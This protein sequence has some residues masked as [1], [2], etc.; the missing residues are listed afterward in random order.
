MVW[1]RPGLY[2]YTQPINKEDIMKHVMLKKVATLLI[3]LALAVTT[4]ACSGGSGLPES[5]ASE[6]SGIDT[7]IPGEEY[8]NPAGVF[9][10]AKETVELRFMVPQHANV[11]DYATNQ[12]TQWLEEKGNVKINFEVIPTADMG[13]KVQ[14]SLASFSDMPDAYLGVAGTP[15]NEFFSATNI[16]RYAQEGQV[17]PLN[18]YIEA[19]G[20]NTKAFLDAYSGGSLGVETLMTSADGNIYYMPS[21]APSIG[22]MTPCKLFVNQTYL[23]ALDLELPTTLDGFYEMLKAFKENDPNGNGLA[24]ELPLVGTDA[25]PALNPANWI[26]QAF[27][28]NNIQFH[29]LYQDN[30][31]LYYAPVTDE[32]REGLK[33]LNQLTTEGLLASI[34]FTQ[35][36]QSVKQIAN[37]P[38]NICGGFTTN[39]LMG[40]VQA[41][42]DE[43]VDRYI[44]MDP[45]NG[46]NGQTAISMTL[47]PG[48]RGTITSAC[49]YPA[50]VFRLFDLMMSE[51][52]SVL[53]RYG[54]E[55][56]HWQ[57]A[58]EGSMSPYGL[59]A[60]I[61]VVENLTEVPQNV[62]WNGINPMIDDFYGNTLYY[63][64]IPRLQQI[65]SE[66][67]T[68]YYDMLAD[69]YVGLLIF[70]PEELEEI[71]DIEVT[72]DE[73][74]KEC[75]AKFAVGEMDPNDDTVWERYLSEFEIIGLDKYMEIGQAVLTRMNG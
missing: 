10:I 62:H 57:A 61:E 14:L 69:N 50:V 29:R 52:A 22:A 58:P 38:N 71:G 9:P 1:I 53:A 7:G 67:S 13:Q 65:N 16:I 46:P 5:S 11:Q 45:L 55:G 17:I 26:M 54:V 59:P 49:E 25:N 37:D 21:I 12:F 4:A 75:L 43:A 27:V 66:T 48:N 30:G 33:Y 36:F 3:I 8:C 6:P 72:L 42:D 40:V 70:T 32:W 23:E 68:S 2:L 35:D 15:G 73:Y 24:D 39:N 64:D 31:Q 47:S 28:P 63:S 41:N 20:E 74:V 19:Y 18:E 60:T 44:G 56:E 34:T 51:E